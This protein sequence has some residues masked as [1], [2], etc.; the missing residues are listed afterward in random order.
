MP[1]YYIFLFLLLVTMAGSKQSSCELC[2]DTYM[3]SYQFKGTAHTSLMGTPP[4]PTT[5]INDTMPVILRR[6]TLIVGDN[7]FVYKQEINGQDTTRY[8]IF[9]F[10]PPYSSGAN[11]GSIKATKTRDTLY[12]DTHLGSPSGGTRTLL[13]GV[14]L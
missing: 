8:S 11:H 4:R 12:Y 2:L 3:G 5:Y 10:I 14:K 6:D 13:V 9:I 7:R 1:V